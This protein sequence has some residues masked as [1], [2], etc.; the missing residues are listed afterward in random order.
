[1]T[2]FFNITIFLVTVARLVADAGLLP[3][4]SNYA[5]MMGWVILG[6]VVL[7]YILYLIRNIQDIRFEQKNGDT[8]VSKY[9]LPAY[10]VFDLFRMLL[11]MGL[12][13]AIIHNL[14][15]AR[16]FL[17]FFLDRMF[18]GIL[19]VA[20]MVV[21]YFCNESTSL[22]ANLIATAVF[23]VVLIIFSGTLAFQGISVLW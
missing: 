6:L 23:V 12:F 14:I 4:L 13:A 1:M 8:V 11:V 16:E 18:Y 19:V 9:Y 10:V 21:D 7:K 15:E 20:A 17:G 5:D 2:V 3:I 22:L